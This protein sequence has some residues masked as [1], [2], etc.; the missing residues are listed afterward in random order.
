MECD[1]DLFIRAGKAQRLRRT[2]ARWASQVEFRMELSARMA[3][4][5]MVVSGWKLKGVAASMVVMNLCCF[6]IIG[7]IENGLLLKDL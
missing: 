3:W 7:G 1:G 4:T 2:K 5:N 6:A